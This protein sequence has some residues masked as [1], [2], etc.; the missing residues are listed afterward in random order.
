MMQFSPPKRNYG[1]YIFDCDGTL[2]DSMSIHFEAWTQGLKAG[3]SKHEL[4]PHG[5]MSVAGMALVQ[6]VEYWEE[7]YGERINLDAVIKAK[8]AYFE[9]NRDRIAPIEPIVRFATGLHEQG[10]PIAVASGGR[11]VDVLW[12]LHHIGI[13][14]LFQVIVTADDVET[15]KPAPDLFLLAAK[16][17]GIEPT[18]CFVLEDSDLGIE[19]ANLAG[20][21]SVRLPSFADL[22]DRLSGNEE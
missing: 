6:T 2:A 13:A 10:R 21:D 1:G 12:T 19:A 17:L 8:N 3:G 16:R 18:E 11:Q 14:D 22:A 20:M 15:A 5:F 7:N 4:S 9:E